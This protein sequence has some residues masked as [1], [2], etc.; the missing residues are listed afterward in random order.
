MH[1]GFLLTKI[2]GTANS[3]VQQLG[4]PFTSHC[5]HLRSPRVLWRKDSSGGPQ[6]TGEN[7]Q[8][9]HERIQVFDLL[10]EI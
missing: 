8:L 6:V 2:G 1:G 3:G 5:L 9:L 7:R 4:P 10:D